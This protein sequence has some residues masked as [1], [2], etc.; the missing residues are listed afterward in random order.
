MVARGEFDHRIDELIELHFPWGQG[1][2]PPMPAAKRTRRAF[3]EAW[4]REATAKYRALLV[5]LLARLCPVIED[6]AARLPDGQKSRFLYRVDLSHLLKT[7]ASILEKMVRRWTPGQPPQITFENFEK[8]FEDLARARVVAN[9]LSDVADI[10]A[11]VR[12]AFSKRPEMLTEAQRGLRGEY[13][14]KSNQLED[15]IALAPGTRQRGER[16]LKGVFSPRARGFEHLQVE[17]QIATVLQEA[18]DQKD[19]FLIYEPRRRGVKPDA[20]DERE[21]FAMSELLYMAD[22]AFDRMRKRLSET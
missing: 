4:L 3:V 20:Q 5:T 19:H 13:Y 21:I 12:D 15:R 9:F 1:A 16:C 17:I 6:V 2:I 7:P 22:I 18:W 14:L 10:G 11:A 8:E